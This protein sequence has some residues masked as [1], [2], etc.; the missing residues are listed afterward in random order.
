MRRQSLSTGET[1]DCR[2]NPTQPFGREVLH[3]NHL[4]KICDAETSAKSSLTRSRQH[5]IRSRCVVPGCLRRVVSNEHRP[6]IVYE[7][8]VVL[9]NSDMFWRKQIRP[10]SRLFTRF[11]NQ[12]RP[13]S[14]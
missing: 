4:H 8:Q 5:V 11:R 13:P 6:G 3:G 12:Y 14:S 10:V 9:G 7:G 2:R 1:L